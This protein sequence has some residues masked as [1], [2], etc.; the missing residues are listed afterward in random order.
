MNIN[1]V[2][3]LK[4]EIYF[5]DDMVFRGMND[6]FHPLQ[7]Y[8]DKAVYFMDTYGF[9]SAQIVDCMTGEIIVEMDQFWHPQSN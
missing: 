9:V 8:V 4:A 3:T 5:E 2:G 6:A 1:Y 7:E